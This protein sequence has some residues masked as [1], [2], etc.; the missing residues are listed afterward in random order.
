MHPPAHV[1]ADRC[2]GPRETRRADGGVALR[3]DGL[4]LLA[5]FHE[6]GPHPART[7]EYIED[8]GSGSSPF[9]AAT[10]HIAFPSEQHNPLIDVDLAGLVVFRS[11]P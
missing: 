8:L 9:D 2:G 6:V 1:P 5:A 3:T 4:R 11:L 10:G 7:I